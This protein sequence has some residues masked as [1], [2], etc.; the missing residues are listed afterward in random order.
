M[1]KNMKNYAV[2]T[3]TILF[4]SCGRNQPQKVSTD[5]I[6]NDATA[7]SSHS[8]KNKGVP[9]ITFEKSIHDFGNI[10]Q[11]EVLEYEFRF[12]NTGNGDLIIANA[13]SSCGCTIPE[14]PKEVIKPGGDGKIKIKFNSEQRLDKF[15]KEVTI[16]ANTQPT[17]TII[18][19][20]G[21]ILSK[22]ENKNK[23]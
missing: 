21:N 2:I 3:L 18:T 12:K 22:P 7:D 4:L 1:N 14:Y 19:I 20:I 10:T 5:I 9:V 15:Q 13:I 16:S 17:E 6:N 8:E 11:G 23:H